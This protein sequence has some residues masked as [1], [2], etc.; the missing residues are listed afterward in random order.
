MTLLRVSR[1]HH[2]GGGWICR[3]DTHHSGMWLWR[4]TLSGLRDRISVYRWRAR[5]GRRVFR[6]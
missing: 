3:L 2:Y 4:P 6:G 1:P 5:T